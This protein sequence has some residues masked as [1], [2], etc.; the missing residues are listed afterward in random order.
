MP[1]T[2]TPPLIAVSGTSADERLPAC[3]PRLLV[4]LLRC[5]PPPETPVFFPCT[6]TDVPAGSYL[7][8]PGQAALC[9]KGEY[10]ETLGPSGNW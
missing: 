7:K 5:L 1:P 2:S 4:C 3:A 9:P 6:P 10:K 8:S